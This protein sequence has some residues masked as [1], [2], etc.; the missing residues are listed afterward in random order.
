MSDGE[1][2]QFLSRSDAFQKM[3]PRSRV[4]SLSVAQRR[5]RA[6]CILGSME[7]QH[8]TRG[9]GAVMRLMSVLSQGAEFD[10]P[11]IVS[12]NEAFGSDYDRIVSQCTRTA[13]GS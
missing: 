7:A 13:S 3:L 11:T 12:F 10:D 8:G 2:A 9:V 4:L 1:I 5:A 6:A